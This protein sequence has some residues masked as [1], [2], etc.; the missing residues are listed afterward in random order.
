M[1]NGIRQRIWTR[2]R[3]W[4]HFPTAFVIHR[5]PEGNGWVQLNI[6]QNVTIF[7]GKKLPGRLI[8]L[9]STLQP[10]NGSEDGEEQG[11]LLATNWSG[12][13]LL[14]FLKF[15][16]KRRLCC[17]DTNPWHD[18]EPATYP[19]W[20]GQS[21]EGRKKRTPPWPGI[22]SVEIWVSGIP[23]TNENYQDKVA[24]GQFVDA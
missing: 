9:S 1:R 23:D 6:M 5:G 21:K 12:S 14:M 22:G 11:G 17:P 13:A 20:A 24:M 19:S 2:R 10:M 3:Y 4:Q 15:S 18:L 16:L 7:E 8:W